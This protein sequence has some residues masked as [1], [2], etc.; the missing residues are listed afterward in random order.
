MSWRPF[1]VSV[2]Y[3]NPLVEYRKFYN[4]VIAVTSHPAPKPLLWR[5]NDH[6]GVSNHQ[7][8]LFTQSFIKKKHQSS[9]SLA[10]GWEIHRDRWIPR[11]KGHLR[12]KC[13]HLMTS[14]C[15]NIFPMQA[16]DLRRHRG[17]YDV[18]VMDSVQRISYIYMCKMNVLW[19]LNVEYSTQLL[20]HRTV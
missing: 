2:P 4:N 11:T 12:G 1:P 19:Q 20:L 13:F 10:F 17:H 7:P 6:D 9:A 14:S 8:R 3:G 5:D 18:T 16:G 15:V